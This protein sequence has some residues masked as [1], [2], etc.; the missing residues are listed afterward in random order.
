VTDGNIWTIDETIFNN[1]TKLFLV[2]NL[3]T[4]AIVG[5][6]IYNNY[7]NEEILIELYE[8]IFSQNS[9]NNPIIIHSDNEPVFSSQ[10]VLDLLSS[11]E[12]KVSYTLANK[13]Q[14]Q[15]SESINERIKTLVTKMLIT[16]DNKSLRNWRKIVPNKYKHLR[17]SNKSRNVEF[18]KLL[19]QS[20]FFEQNKIKAIT[21]AISEYNRTDFT[22]GISRQEAK[23]YNTKLETKAFEYIQLVRSDDL[24]ATKIQ[25]VKLELSKILSLDASESKKIS[26]IASLIVEAKVKRM[27]Y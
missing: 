4:R 3:K 18:C 6:A 21:Y 7:L 9:T 11:K 5:Y 2:I 22:L 1:K 25:K 24:I 15:V 19:F 14:N 20:D 23:Y 10:T 17:I 16:Q 8:E 27:S 26:K 13:N 12:I